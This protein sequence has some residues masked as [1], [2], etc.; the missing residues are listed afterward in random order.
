[1]RVVTLD[2][3]PRCQTRGARDFGVPRSTTAEGE[4]YRI[5]S[6]PIRLFPLGEAILQYARPLSDVNHTVAKVRVFL[7][8]GIL[9]GAGLAL[10][11]GLAISRRAMRPIAELTGT[12]REIERTRDPSLRVP[13][14]EA[15]DEVAELARTLEGML[16][17]LDEARTETE[18]MLG[19]QRRFIADASHELRT[20]LTSVLANLELLS[21]QLEGERKATADSALRSSQ[22]MRRLVGDLLL[23]ARADAGRLPPR[24]PTD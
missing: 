1:L 22:R 9:G 18:A 20:P 8:L 13:H 4:G 21:V 3:T 24:A 2:G 5:E 17:A 7:A 19:R 16:K 15:D 23:L 12:A 6:R 10:L 14:P 11:A